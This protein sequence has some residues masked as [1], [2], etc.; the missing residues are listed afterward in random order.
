MQLGFALWLCTAAVTFIA[1][2]AVM[3]VYVQSAA[4]YAL[5]LGLIL[6]CLGNLVMVRLIREGGLGLAISASSIAQLVLV[7]LI[8]VAFFDEQLSAS[9]LIGLA[10]GVIAMVLLLFP[11]AQQ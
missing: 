11:G 3:K 6:Y 10:F 5:M 7:N 9:Q 1:A 4:L 8:A 2:S